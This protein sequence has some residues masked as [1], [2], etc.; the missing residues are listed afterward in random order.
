MVGSFHC[1]VAALRFQR[2]YQP[3]SCCDDIFYGQRASHFVFLSTCDDHTQRQTVTTTPHDGPNPKTPNP[4]AANLLLDA[5]GETAA[6][7]GSMTLRRNAATSCFL[8]PTAKSRA[9]L[10]HL[11]AGGKLQTAKGRAALHGGRTGSWRQGQI[12]S[13]PEIGKLRGDR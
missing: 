2:F 8:L 3:L 10:P 5:G 7:C 13:G 6:H 4:Q 11:Q 9:D 12:W 1:A